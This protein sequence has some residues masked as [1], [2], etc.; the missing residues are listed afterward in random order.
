MTFLQPLL[1]A[2]LPLIGLPILIHMINRQRHRTIPWA[3]MM[4]L[5]D[6]KRMARGMA[7]LRY[8]LIMA[9]R[10]L[11]IAGLVFAA[12][13]PLT[14][15]VLGTAVGG[16][17]DTTLV[18]LD[19]SAS[20][21]QQDGPTGPSKRSTCLKKLSNLLSTVGAGTQI[22]L[23]DSAEHQV[24]LLESSDRL[25]DLPETG[26][27]AT[28]ADIPS[29]LQ[30]ALDYVV[31]NQ[32]GRTDIWIASDLRAADWKS[33]DG[34]WQSLVA[35]F[36]ALDGI[37]VYL[38]CYPDLAQDNLSV[39]ATNVR[40]RTLGQTTELVLDVIVRRDSNA[41]SRLDVPLEFVLGDARSVIKVEMTDQE[42]VLQ[43]HT[44]PLD[45]AN[46]T[47]WGIVEIPRDSNPQDNKSY[48]VYADPPEHHTTIVSDNRDFI[49][50][51]MSAVTSPPD[52][53]LQYSVTVLATNQVEQIDFDATSLLVWQA[54]LPTTDLIQ[55]LEQF[56]QAGRPILFFPPESP[57]PEQAFQIAWNDWQGSPAKPTPV[58]SWRGDSD[59]LMHTRNGDPL[60]VGTLHVSKFSPI[61]GEGHVL[62]RLEGGIP[63]LLRSRA[64]EGPVYFLGTWPQQTHSSLKRDGVVFYVMLQRL[65][66]EGA[67]TQGTARQ[68]VADASQAALV[69]PAIPLSSPAEDIPFTARSLHAGA[70]QIDEQL[71]ALN[72]PAAEDL[73]ATLDVGQIERLI[74]GLDYRRV[75]DQIGN[76]TG[77]AREIWRAFLFVMAAALIVEAWL[78]LP[79]K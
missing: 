40:R 26:P 50:S 31:N 38:L 28:A 15:G 61:T 46:V 2:A 70:Y 33:E 42:Y 63:L 29:L 20:M 10:M 18:L 65:L 64:M 5:R 77:L 9:M 44:L 34:R 24:Q 75:E 79:E 12:A 27:T 19:R 35:G 60:P 23:I 67:A 74:G 30:V 71:I 3:A 47:G 17:P 11:A 49:Q 54:P 55:P 52:L 69:D 51:I 22:V 13:R 25:A 68:L 59:V 36:Q 45:R 6:A 39:R 66:S 62:A 43:G 7:Q 57:G 4:F 1:L 56:V 76:D 58:T 78:C 53:S 72:R 32:T 41:T 16:R 14:S 21:Q 73:A 37:R 48:F 8:W